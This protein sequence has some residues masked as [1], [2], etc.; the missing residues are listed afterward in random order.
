VKTVNGNPLITKLHRM[1]DGVHSLS[2]MHATGVSMALSWNRVLRNFYKL[3][4]RFDQL[5]SIEGRDA[6]KYSLET[7]TNCLLYGQ[8]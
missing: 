5:G 8:F 4:R 7:S 2:P 1:L 3:E 6:S